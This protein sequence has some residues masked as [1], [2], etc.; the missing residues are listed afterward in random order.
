MKIRNKRP[1][2]WISR[3]IVVILVVGVIAIIAMLTLAS[4]NQTIIDTSYTFNRA[5]IN[6][7]D[8]VLNVEIESWK[9]YD[10]SD[11]VQVK[12]KDGKVYYGHSS[13]IILVKDN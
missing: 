11:Q 3:G 2:D 8:E 12:T 13:N 9:D 6:I 7:G 5:Y 10:D 4:C 1:A